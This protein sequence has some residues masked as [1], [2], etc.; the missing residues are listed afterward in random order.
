MNDHEWNEFLDQR[1]FIYEQMKEHCES[2]LLYII[3][4]LVELKDIRSKLLIS[5]NKGT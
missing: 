5:L 4:S 2:N 1:I 3:N